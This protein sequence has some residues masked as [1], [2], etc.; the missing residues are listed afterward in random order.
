MASSTHIHTK[1]RS[2]RKIEN[3][4]SVKLRK[5]TIQELCTMNS[6]VLCRAYFRSVQYAVE[7]LTFSSLNV[8]DV[9]RIALSMRNIPELQGSTS[10][11]DE[12]HLNNERR[13]HT[14]IEIWH[15]F[16]RDKLL[17]QSAKTFFR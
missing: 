17:K 13:S 11:F 7:I 16:S 2:T 14:R 8:F 6:M 12:R 5:Q 4:K 1:R 9:L 3:Q 15:A 10:N